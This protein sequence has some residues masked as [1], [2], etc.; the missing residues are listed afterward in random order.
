METETSQSSE[1]ISDVK[2]AAPI[3]GAVLVAAAGIVFAVHA[4][5]GAEAETAQKKALAE[6]NQQLTSQLSATQNQLAA[7]SAKVNALTSTG[8]TGPTT[9]NLAASATGGRP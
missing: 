1:F 3:L 2:R 9:E 6:Q 5:N 8:Q 4:H 7:L